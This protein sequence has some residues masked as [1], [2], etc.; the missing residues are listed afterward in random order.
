[1]LQLDIT[2]SSPQNPLSILFCKISLTF[3]VFAL[4]SSELFCVYSKLISY[5][6]DKAQFISVTAQDFDK[7]SFNNKFIVFTSSILTFIFSSFLLYFCI[8]VIKFLISSF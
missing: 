7:L 1:L 6:L 5:T 2:T 3:S 8:S 4:S